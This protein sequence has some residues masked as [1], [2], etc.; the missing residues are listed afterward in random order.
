MFPAYA[1]VILKLAK[2]TLFPIS[3][4]RVCGG[5]PKTINAYL[6]GA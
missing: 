3:V 4:P 1:G 2:L 6:M 5:D